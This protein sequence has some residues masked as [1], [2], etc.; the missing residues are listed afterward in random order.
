MSEVMKGLGAGLAAVLSVTA[1]GHSAWATTSE[2]S[3][4]AP[5]SIAAA[6][7]AALEAAGGS[8]I[9]GSVNV[10]GVLGGEELDDFL[11]VIEPF[12]E[13][14]GI[15]VEYE[16]TRDF[17]AVLQT[18]VDGGNPPELAVTPAIG[19]IAELADEGEVIDLRGVLGDEVLDAS[20]DPGLIAT[21][22]NDEIVFGAFNTI[23][24]GGLMWYNPQAY[25]G[26]TE[27]ESW[28]ELIEWATRKAAEGE[29]PFCVTLE[30]GAASGWPAADF[31]DEIVLR[32]A[33]PEF[34]TRWRNLE[35]DWT[36][37]E[38][39]RAY[40]TYGQMITPQGMAFGDVNSILGTNFANAADP[41]FG[42]EPGCFLTQ[43]A[44]FMGGII[45]GNFP[46]LTPVDDYDFFA[47]PDFSTEFP[48]LRGIGGE[49]VAMF[50]E[51]PQSVAL[52]EYLV[53]VEA[54]T[55]IAETGRWLSPNRQVDSSSYVDPFLSKASVILQESD[56]SYNLANSLMPQSVVDAF[57]HSGL[58]YTQD[59]DN[60]DEILATVEAARQDA[61]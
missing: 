3:G 40:E 2:S 7:V 47:V 9:G 42:D 34:H 26:P 29:S 61:L 21:A 38:I 19:L 55:L 13:A 52:T 41:M 25:D 33:G 35:V 5:D 53:S 45:A 60:L 14:T 31:I 39:R 58:E 36:A 15:D 17:G 48:N 12:E 22:S 11:A 28:D 27:P 44:T 18:R 37:P 54:G 23:N 51:T 43:Q 50:E 49:I 30:S 10:L 4:N 16:G 57:W 24:L 8:E 56:G 20:F 1:I 32:Q 6:R 59:P 46:D